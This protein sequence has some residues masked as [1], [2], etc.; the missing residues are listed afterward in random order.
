MTL[1][2]VKAE[3]ESSRSGWSG[4]KSGSDSKNLFDVGS[5][6]VIAKL[7]RIKA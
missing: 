6:N 4:V 1:E 3:N 2:V 7:N 5:L